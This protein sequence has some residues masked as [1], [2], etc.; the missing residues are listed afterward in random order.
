MRKKIKDKKIIA[1]K[2]SHIGYAERKELLDKRVIIKYNIHHAK[3]FSGR[4]VQDRL[5]RR[6]GHIGL[7]VGI[8]DYDYIKVFFTDREICEV[9]VVQAFFL[10]DTSRI[11]QEMCSCEKDVVAAHGGYE[12]NK[13]CKI[14]DAARNDCVDEAL[15]LAYGCAYSYNFITYVD[16]PENYPPHISNQEKWLEEHLLNRQKRKIMAEEAKINVLKEIHAF[17]IN[18]P[19]LFRE[20]VRKECN[21]SIPTFYRKMRTLIDSPIGM[22]PTISNAEKEAILRQAGIVEKAI[23]D[24]LDKFRKHKNQ[25]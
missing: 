14:Y 22:I 19:I 11:Y 16:C 4:S 18:A 13:I 3:L 8:V 5:H 17:F 24:F 9:P 15:E 12:Y 23:S 20:K 1:F 21:Y 25:G 6:I 2:P 10:Q 7:V